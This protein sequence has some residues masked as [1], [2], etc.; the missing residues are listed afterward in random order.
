MMLGLTCKNAIGSHRVHLLASN[1]MFYV[2]ILACAQ[3]GCRMWVS[4]VY[5]L[6]RRSRPLAPKPNRLT[7]EWSFGM[8]Y[9]MFS[10]FNFRKTM[11]LDGLPKGLASM[12]PSSADPNGV[13]KKTQRFMLRFD[14]AKCQ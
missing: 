14:A 3:V 9:R 8:S 11:C 6:V 2:S 12:K 5:A 7:G 13:A 1:F 4:K 10:P